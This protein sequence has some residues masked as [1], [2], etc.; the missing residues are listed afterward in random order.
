MIVN[1]EKVV[2]NVEAFKQGDLHRISR[3]G[4]HRHSKGNIEDEGEIC[5]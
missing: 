2:L 5:G 4:A 1:K 3:D